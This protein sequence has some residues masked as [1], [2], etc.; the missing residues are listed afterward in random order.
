M[1]TEV[2]D[3][4]DLYRR[5]HIFR[6]KLKKGYT[7][8]AFGQGELIEEEQII[9]WAFFHPEGKVCT[10]EFRR[11]ETPE[12]HTFHEMPFGTKYTPEAFRAY[13]K[14]HR[15]HLSKRVDLATFIEN[16]RLNV[17]MLKRHPL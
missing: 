8:V 9:L 7:E 5:R 3:S 1:K 11:V 6:E 4:T 14:R 2:L 13:V 16:R 12:G 10:Y 15:I 17:T